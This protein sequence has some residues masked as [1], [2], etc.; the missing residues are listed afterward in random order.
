M[1]LAGHYY[2]TNASLFK[3]VFIMKRIL[4]KTIANLSLGLACVS[5][6]T[7]SNF[8]IAGRSCETNKTTTPQMIQRSLT[9]A[10]RTMHLLNAEFQSNDTQL[11]I[12]ARAG[13]D[14]SRYG[15]QYSHLGFA[16]RGADGVWVVTHKLNTCGTANAY[17]FRQ[18]LGDFFL[19]DPFRYEAAWVV[20]NR[21]IQTKI[22]ALLEDNNRVAAFNQRA[23]SM[24]SYP[25]SQRYQQSNQWALETLA[26]ALEPSIQSRQQAQ[27]WLQYKGYQ[28]S[29]LNIS[30]LTRLG[31][32][33][34]SAN[35]AFDDHPSEKRFADRIETVTVDSVFNWLQRSGMSTSPRLVNF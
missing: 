7:F 21:E 4:Y 1:K 22:K 34:T 11:V 25:W 29:V 15:L 9:L 20:P 3:K 35:V 16:H 27:S 18:G 12:L 19:D 28:P 14:L 26:G 8:A 33:I 24:V 32:R 30:A 31:G 6:L 5:A 2:A 13:Q 23:Y 10:E 17:L